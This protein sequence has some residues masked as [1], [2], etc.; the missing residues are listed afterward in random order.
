V[1]LVDKLEAKQA[2]EKAEWDLW[3]KEIYISTGHFCLSGMTYLRRPFKKW[4]NV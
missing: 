1:Q 3:K 4:I 2:M